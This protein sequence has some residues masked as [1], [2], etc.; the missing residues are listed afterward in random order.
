MSDSERSP[1]LNPKGKPRESPEAEDDNSES[2]PL[3]SSSAA[4]PRYDGDQDEPNDGDAVSVA[5]HDS[6]VSKKKKKKKAVRFMPWPSIVAILMLVIVA[7]VVLLLAFFLPA[8]VEEYAK[9]AAVLEPTNLSLESITS[10]GVKARIQANFR[11]DGSR[12]KDDSSRR[13]GR[14]ATWVVRKLGT[15]E[16]KV[17]VYLPE[18]EGTLLGSAVVP[19]LVINIVDG[20]TTA[21]DF[22]A[23]LAPGDAEAYRTIAN[24]W[25]E[26]KLDKL[27]V[28]GKAD[29]HLKSGIIPLGTHPIVE[30]MV[31]EGGEIPSMPEYN[32]TRVSFHDVETPG[33]GRGAVGADISVTAHNDFPVSMEVPELGFQVL[34]PSC[35]GTD[36]RIV[37]ADVITRHLTVKPRADIVVDAQGLIQELPTEFTSPCPG[38][39]S[40]PM[41]DF[42]TK[43]LNGDPPTVYVRG[44]KLPE[45]KT[46]AWIGDIL[47]KI[48]V[49]VPFP[50]QGMGEVIRSFSLTDVNFKLPSPMADP[51]DPDGSPKVSGTI[52]VLAALPEEMNFGINVTNLRATA[53]VLYKGDKM[54]VLNLDRW[55]HANS[56]RVKD[57]DEHDPLLK[58]QSRVEE[59]PLNITD[60]DVFSDVM[61]KLFFGGEDVVLDVYAKVDVQIKTALGKVI[62]RDVPAEGSV[63]VKH[64]PGDTLGGL[65]PQVG[66]I[67]IL[68]TS[69]SSVDI[70]AMV[71]M[72]NP[73][74]YAAYIPYVNIHIAKNGSVLGSATAENLNLT[75]GNNTNIRVTARWDANVAGGKGKKIGAELLSQYLSG[76]NVTLDVQTHRDSIPAVPLIGE[77]LSHLNISIPAPKLDLPSEDGE[78]GHFIRDAVFHV[79]SSTATFTLVSPLHYNTL[80][81]DA[82]NATAYYNHTAP[83]GRIDYDLPF[84]VTPGATKTPKLPVQWSV[85]SIGYDAVKKALGGVLKLDAKANVTVRIG[86]WRETVWYTGKGIGAHISL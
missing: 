9:E 33:D 71:N 3:L 20:H 84:A 55:N 67:K 52:L 61:A 30:T 48:V 57:E 11:L 22:I 79:I 51:D 80:Y 18:Y 63:P 39:D 77:A 69:S 40:S 12:V 10:D 70:E 1:L 68:G 13:L 73:T 19:P 53:D 42:I 76:Y 25:L 5:S 75:R 59:V 31:F 16:T 23:D 65:S 14:F 6:T 56:T 44:Q 50:S 36:D 41:D 66:E 21:I 83:V 43:Y 35:N 86:N 24:N 29:I 8:A 27:K 34:V 47:S 38:S 78:E 37:I 17:N 85:G 46:P 15:D 54:G 4:T 49:P 60:G 58:I 26:G 82:V 45:S 64:L 28:L 7:G 72:T 32:I 81:I 2:A 74:P 62:L